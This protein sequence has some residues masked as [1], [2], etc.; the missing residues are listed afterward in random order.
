MPKP[1]KVWTKPTLEVV[2]VRTAAALLSGNTSDGILGRLLHRS[3]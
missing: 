3:I 1:L 2:L